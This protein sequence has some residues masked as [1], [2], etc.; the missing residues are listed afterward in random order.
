MANRQ[1]EFATEE[2]YHC[3]TRSIDKKRVFKDANDYSRFLESLYL[4]NGSRNILRGALYHP[5]REHI[6]GLKRSEPLV[7]I[8]AYC[9]MPNH[10]HLLLRQIVDKGISTFMQKMGTSFAMYYNRKYDHV[11]NVFIKPFRAKH[12]GQDDYFQR[13]VQY[14]HLNPVEIFEPKW[15]EGI[16]GNMN[17]L[18]RQLEGYRYSSLVDY[19]G[20]KRLENAIIDSKTANLFETPPLI[21]SLLSE[22]AE[23]YQEINL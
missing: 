6:F 10:F 14:I 19:V 8:G 2:W 1:V 5:S 16:V 3:Y 21:E 12:I 23:Y 9:L 18:S 22:A 13:V 20:E 15:K 17:K 7:A 4:C 11:G